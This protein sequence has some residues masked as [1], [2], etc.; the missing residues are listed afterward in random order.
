MNNEL[1]AYTA[2]R[3][4]LSAA[5]R[6]TL[7]NT[8]IT[9]AA[10]L[11]IT[12][13]A[14]WAMIGQPVG[15]LT[16]VGLLIAAI[17]LIFLLRAVKDSAWGLVVLAAF[18]GIMGALMGPALTRHLELANGAQTVATAFG[19]TAAVV[20]GCAV[21]TL[22]TRRDF[23]HLH[24]ILFSGLIVL[25]LALVLNMFLAIPALGLALSAFGALLFTGWLLY[26]LSEVIHGR[27]TNY[28]LAAISVYLDIIN[29]FTSLLN[30]LGL[31]RD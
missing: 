10:M 29:L 24:A 26:D 12:A 6:K 28:V 16:L 18:S 4:A 21:Y 9:V 3:P 13:V 14:S 27:E 2:D 22:T 23:K 25:L 17:G 5:I 7:A 19:L 11:G 15:L 20:L 30:L 1:G 31:S 8:F